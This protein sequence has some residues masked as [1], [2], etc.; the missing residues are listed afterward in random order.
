LLAPR[1]VDKREGAAVPDTKSLKT[2]EQFV[3]ALARNDIGT[4]GVSKVSGRPIPIERL[5]AIP[6]A[7]TLAS[8]QPL[9]PECYSGRT[10]CCKLIRTATPTINRGKW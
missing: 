7:A 8:E 10:S 9:E 1:Y 2:P 3:K 6:Y 4:Y 5:E